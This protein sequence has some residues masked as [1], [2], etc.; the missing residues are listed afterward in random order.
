M[1]VITRVCRDH[2]YG[3]IGV[4]QLF[5]RENEAS[6]S[7]VFFDRNPCGLLEQPACLA[8][9]KRELKLFAHI[10]KVAMD[11]AASFINKLF[12]FLDPPVHAAVDPLRE[13]SI[14]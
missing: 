13:Y 7:G 1:S 10:A 8:I 3:L 6:L 14:D 4:L 5:C 12:Q 11:L 9:R 2:L